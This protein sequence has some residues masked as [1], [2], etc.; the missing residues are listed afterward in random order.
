MKYDVIIIGAGLS[1]LTAGSLLAKRGLKVALIDR[2]YTPGGSCGIF[3]RDDIIF[4][5]G[6]A[7]LFGFGENGFNPHRFLFNSLEEPIDMI[8]HDLLYCV[9]YRGKRIKFW[10]DI[11]KFT[12]ELGEAFPGEKEN[13]KKFYKDLLKIYQD[14]MVENPVFSTPDEVDFLSS[15]KALIKH[16]LS[17]IRFLSFLNKSTESLLQ[18]YFSDPDIFWFFF[19]LTSTYC[20]TTAKETPAI[21]GAIMFIDNHVGGSYYPAGSTIFL[22]GKLE[23]VVEENGGEMLLKSE[24]IKIIFGEKAPIAVKLNNGEIIYADDFIY[25]GTIWNLYGKL[26]DENDISPKK[27]K[28][29]ERQIPTYPSIVLFA[30]VDKRYIP[31]DTLPVEMLVGNPEEIDESEVTIYIFSIDDRTLCDA[32]SHV[33]MAIGPSFKNWKMEDKTEYNRQKEEER[34]RL[35]DLLEKRFPGFREGLKYSEVATPKTLERFTMKNSGA[36][37]GPKQMLGQHMLK[38]LHT[39]SNWKTL[40]FSGESTV[41]GTGTP[42]VTVS[43]ISAANA[44]LKKRRLETFKYQEGMKNFVIIVDKPYEKKD[45]FAK[46]PQEQKEIMQKAWRCLFCARPN[47][48]KPA[49]LDVRGIMRRVVVGNF[50]GAEKLARISMERDNREQFLEKAQG[51]CIKNMKGEGPVEIKAVIDYLLQEK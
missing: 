39:K 22:P 14:I 37:A 25:S 42:A 35:I 48:A 46:Y 17:Q 41:M 34:K 13:I 51:K 44:I 18:K 47:C 49:D 21:L 7:M 38:R 50:Y 15:F 5:Q 43:G 26:I 6:A 2:N 19:N 29:A 4:D 9:N 11:N 23:K 10:A 28:W 8:K 45:L 40:F 12:E 33:V 3:K 1:G 30:V 20:Y 27:V 24:V 31:S 16:P 32:D 36:V